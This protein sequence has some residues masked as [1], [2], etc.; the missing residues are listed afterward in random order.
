MKAVRITNRLLMVLLLMVLLLKLDDGSTEFMLDFFCSAVRG[1]G[2]HALGGN[3]I[4]GESRKKN[5]RF[6]RETETV[7]CSNYIEF[8]T[9]AA[10]GIHFPPKS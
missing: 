3:T 9:F 7:I 4:F 6:P 10:T 1:V 2:V 8:L 5:P